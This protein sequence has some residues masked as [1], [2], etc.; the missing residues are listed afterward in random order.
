MAGSTLGNC[1]KFKLPTGQPG[2]PLT[3][4]FKADQAQGFL[5]SYSL[6]MNKG[7]IGD[8]PVTPPPPATA[9]FRE[10]SYVHGDDLACSA[11]R[12]TFDDPTH[13]LVSGYVTIDLAPASGHWL[14]STENFCAFSVNLVAD[15]RKTD[16]YSGGVTP[17]SNAVPVLI[18][19]EA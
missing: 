7:A 18:G 1:A 14:E 17:H 9:P 13:D 15:M 12:G 3:V 5:S 11:F 8:F 2:A 10:G 16:G 19:I 4:Q 6:S